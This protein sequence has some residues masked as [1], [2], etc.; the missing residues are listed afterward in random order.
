MQPTLRAV[1]ACRPQCTL[2]SSSSTCAATCPANATRSR[3]AA[4]STGGM[5][6]AAGALS[7]IF[8][9]RLLATKW[10]R[11]PSRRTLPS[12]SSAGAIVALRPPG[13]R[14][15]AP[16]APHSRRAVPQCLCLS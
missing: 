16:A 3:S 8:R 12:T 7:G 1:R 13:G 4:G 9:C 5:G 11:R 10:V 14:A 2:R 6:L 15:P